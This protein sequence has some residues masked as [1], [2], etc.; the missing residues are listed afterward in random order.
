MKR[1]VVTADD[2]GLHRGMTDAAIRGHEHGIVTA[3]SI[4]ACG[5]DVEKAANAVR[6]VPALDAGVHFTL[7]EERPL[8]PAADIKSLVFRDGKFAGGY[9]E[10]FVRYTLGRIDLDEVEAELRAQAARLRDLGVSLLHANG[11]QHLH[12]LPGIF[13]RVLRV[14]GDFGIRYVRIPDDA[15]RRS[16]GMRELQVSALSRFARAAARIAEL[17]GFSTN[18]RTI[19]IRDAGH[20]DA[21]RIVELLDHVDGVTELVTH[22]GTGEGLAESYSWS[23]DWQREADALCDPRVREECARRDIELVSVRDVVGAAGGTQG[24]RDASPES[25]G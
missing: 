2:L 18:D 24:P 9:R 4:S 23:Y 12:V 11:H 22:P 10:L 13:E 7:V 3:C 5:I 17:R 16:L 14:A 6:S 19:G 1:L 8:L 25:T 21:D 15:A 20:L